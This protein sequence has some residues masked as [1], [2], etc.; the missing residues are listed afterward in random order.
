MPPKNKSKRGTAPHTNKKTGKSAHKK[1]QQ[2]PRLSLSEADMRTMDDDEPSLKSVKALL[3]SMN[4]RMGT[5]RKRLKEMTTDPSPAQGAYTAPPEPSTGRV[6]DERGD[7]RQ[8][9]VTAP[10]SFPD[11]AK[12]VHGPESSN[13]SREP[14]PFSCT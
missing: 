11:M 4:S 12:E 3:G 8:P 7:L 5:Y 1:K 13:G 9:M 6:M 14:Q 10:D 2:P